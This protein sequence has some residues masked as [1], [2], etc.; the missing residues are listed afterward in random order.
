MMR[1]LLLLWPKPPAIKPPFAL[2]RKGD[3]LGG[4]VTSQNGNPQSTASPRK[5]KKKL[6]VG[7]KK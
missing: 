3:R 6:R 2:N 7:Q 1:S 5:E 4:K